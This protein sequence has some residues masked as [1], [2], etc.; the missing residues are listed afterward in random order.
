MALEESMLKI[1]AVQVEKTPCPTYYDEELDC[2]FSQFDMIT[3]SYWGNLT[4]TGEVWVFNTDDIPAYRF[5]V[6]LE[7]L[8]GT[9]LEEIKLHLKEHIRILTEPTDTERLTR[10]LGYDP[11]PDC[12]YF[13]S[14]ELDLAHVTSPCEKHQRHADLLETLFSPGEKTLLVPVLQA[15]RANLHR[16]DAN[17]HVALDHPQL[18]NPGLCALAIQLDNENRITSSQYNLFDRFT[19]VYRNSRAFRTYFGL[20]PHTRAPYGS[21]WFAPGDI[22]T[23]RAWL[24]RTIHALN[25]TQR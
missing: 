14:A 11:C 6:T 16:I 13:L 21:Y 4:D 1:G 22:P 5:K 23:R 9:D 15:L 25:P 7:F 3:P 18:Y 8:A 20:P 12:Q 24:D 17:L 19:W 2:Y 10:I